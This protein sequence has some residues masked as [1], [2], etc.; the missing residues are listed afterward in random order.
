M[1][2]RPDNYPITNTDLAVLGLIAEGPRHGYQVE[3]DIAARGMREWTEIGFSSIYYVLNKLE[4]AGWLESRLEAEALAGKRGPARKI[5]AL[6]ENGRGIYRSAVQQRLASPRPRSA[7]FA[8]ALANLPAISLAEARA[9]IETQRA[10]LA[11][12]LQA[13]QQK[14]R[15]DRQLAGNL[16]AHVEALFSYSEAQ[17][18]AELGWLARF[19]AS[20]IFEHQGE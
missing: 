8:L 18:A 13:V 12:R 16:P 3:Q 1:P 15:L 9:A 20:G 5:Y 10:A 11:E 7:D 4:S 14:N 17:M 6:T 19:L 2:E